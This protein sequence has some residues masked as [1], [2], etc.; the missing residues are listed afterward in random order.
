MASGKGGWRLEVGAW[1]LPASTRS[2]LGEVG[3]YVLNKMCIPNFGWGTPWGTLGDPLT[4]IPLGGFYCTLMIMESLVDRKSVH[5]EPL[6][7]AWLIPRKGGPT[8]T[9]GDPWGAMETPLGPMETHLDPWGPMGT[10]GDPWGPMGTT[11]GPMGAN[12]GPMGT[13]GGPWGPVGS[14]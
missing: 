3:G 2:T 5:A 10:Y 11:W 13:H 14:S 8:E 7:E 4:L 6:L 1:K 9:H 12:G